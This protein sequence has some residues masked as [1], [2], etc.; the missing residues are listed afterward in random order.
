MRIKSLKHIFISTLFLSLFCL[1][2]F[3]QAPV[4]NK[5]VPKKTRVLFVFDCSGSMLA[6][7]EGDSR[8]NIAKKILGDLVDSL[9][10]NKNVEIALR[11]YGHQYD[12]VFQNCKDT[13]LEVPFSPKSHDQIKAKLKTLVPRGTTPIAYSM[14]QAAND[15]PNDPNFRNVIIIITDG[16]ESCNGDPC[17]LSL[18]LQKNRI[19][20]KPFIIGLGADDDYGKAFDCMGQFFEAKTVAQFKS[21]LGKIINQTLNK[22]TVSVKLLD[23][24]D[25]PTETNVNVSFINNVTGEVVYDFIHYLDPATN[26]TDTLQIDAVIS[27]DV[28]VS[29]IPPKIKRDVYLEGGKHNI[30]EVKTPQGTL[31]INFEG[32]GNDYKNLNAII[33]QSDSLET[34]HN[35]KVGSK[36]KFIVGTYDIE[37]LTLPR[38]SFNKVQINQNNIT[39]L[40][41]AQPG[42][43]SIPVATAG[44]GSLYQI[45]PNSGDHKWIYNFDGNSK[46]NMPMQPGDYKM[47]FRAKGTKGAKYTEVQ[48]FTIKSGATS[49]VKLNGK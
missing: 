8:M 47:V 27:Y 21:V 35:Y 40:K 42:V 4:S 38:I 34:L 48:Y 11:A 45:V 49:L 23:I 3:A 46:V 32:G 31:N 28:M 15:F 44:W 14:E 25:K 36:E 1:S 24:Y 9:K 30:V 17:A 7:W 33:R 22:T 13:K 6:T 37:V 39:N 19:F 12:K 10:S 26:N 2:S 18:A 41:I 5:E 20:L 43:L 29:T 16:L